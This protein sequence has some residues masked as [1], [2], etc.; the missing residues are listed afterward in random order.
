MKK[1]FTLIELLVVVLIIGILAAVALPQYQMV[2]E[3][4]RFVQ[5]VTAAKA[6]IDAEQIYYMANGTYSSSLD[7]L[8]V[9]FQNGIKDFSLYIHTSPSLHVEMLRRKRIDGA[10]VWVTA[11]LKDANRPEITC[12][13]AK[14]T[15]A[16]SRAR[17]LCKNL[18]GSNEPV[19]MESGY[20]SY[21]LK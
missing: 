4:S 20:D 10:N 5:G 8:D 21:I 15:A 9:S 7:E 16:S 1:G 12:T 13:L 3:K 18:S 11:Y 2:V 14:G 19:T 17:K 6:L